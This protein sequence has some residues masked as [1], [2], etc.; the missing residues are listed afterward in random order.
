MLCHR[1]IIIWFVK[2]IREDIFHCHCQQDCP[3]AQLI[4]FTNFRIQRYT[5]MSSTLSLWFTVDLSTTCLVIGNLVSSWLI[6]SRVWVRVNRNEKQNALRRRGEVK[7]KLFYKVEKRCA[8]LS[9]CQKAYYETT[10]NFKKTRRRGEQL[11]WEG[12][13]GAP[14]SF[15]IELYLSKF[16][17][18]FGRI[19]WLSNSVF[20]FQHSP[21]TSRFITSEHSWTKYFSSQVNFRLFLYKLAKG[22]S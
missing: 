9:L 16:G 20:I 6:A 2:K 15:L 12:G 18:T 4:H 13:N 3:I 19:K 17:A 14:K 7:E 22:S 8:S 21:T 5:L 11:R 10:G 1:V